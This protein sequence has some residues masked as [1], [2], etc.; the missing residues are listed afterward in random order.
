MKK[1]LIGLAVL[2]VLLLVCCGVGMGV[3]QDYR[4]ERSIDIAAPPAAIHATVADLP[5][6]KEWTVWTEAEDP[7]CV[8]QF[9]G[10][11]GNVDHAMEWEGPVHMDGRVL[12]TALRPDSGGIE[13]DMWSRQGAD[14]SKGHF[15]IE[16]NG[17]GSTVTWAFWGEAPMLMTAAMDSMVGP[18]FEGGLEGLKARH[19]GGTDAAQEEPVD[20]TPAE[21]PAEGE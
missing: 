16:P 4:V 18:M 17:D 3:K 1:V 12:I 9:E 21:T 14:F 11:P 10:E 6:W 20:E 15:V 2:V 5:T 7:A 19:E 13:Y 8:W